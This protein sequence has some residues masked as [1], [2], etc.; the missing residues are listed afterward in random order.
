MKKDEVARGVRVKFVEGYEPRTLA[1]KCLLELEH[2][3]F[4]PR[5]KIF[6]DQN[7]S[8]VSICGASHTNTSFAY[9]KDLE[10]EFPIDELYRGKLKNDTV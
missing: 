8:Y 7:G 5:Q 1:D 4:I 9:L 3:I 2:F 10:L 6:N